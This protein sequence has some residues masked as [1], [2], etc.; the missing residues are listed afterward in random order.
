MMKTKT[1]MKAK[2]API[3]ARVEAIRTAL[4]QLWYGPAAVV[5]ICH[6]PTHCEH[7]QS[8]DSDFK[9]CQW[10]HVVYSEEIDRTPEQIED[11]I[12]TQQQG[13]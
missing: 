6:G 11:D 3:P 9:M 1:K 7:A 4:D 5:F 10:C 8:E 12:L 2:A 13:H